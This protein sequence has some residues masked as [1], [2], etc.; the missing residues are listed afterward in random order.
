VRT[1]RY[2]ILFSYANLQLASLLQTSSSPHTRS[3]RNTPT[4]THAPT[5]PRDLADME[6]LKAL[7]QILLLLAT[8]PALETLNAWLHSSPRTI[9]PPANS[10]FRSATS[11]PLALPLR[12][13]G[14]TAEM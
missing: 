7:I 6:L 13:R 14:S 11:Y 5:H 3:Y 4:H 8:A 10:T 1:L 12:P 9:S 2:K